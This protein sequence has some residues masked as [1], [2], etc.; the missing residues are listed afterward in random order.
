MKIFFSFLI[1][2][3]I[4]TPCF[5]QQDSSTIIKPK[6]GFKKYIIP[7]TFIVYGLSTFDQNGLPSSNEVKNFRDRNYSDF[8]TSMDD[9]LVFA[10]AAILYTFDFLKV[11]GKS[12]FLN[13]N[14]ICAKAL[15]LSLGLTY[16]LKYTT[17]ITRPDGSDN[18]SFCS[19][20]SAAAFTFAEV[21]HQ[22]F[23]EKPWIA[24]SGY[25]LATSVAAMRIANNKHW[26]SD[27]LVGAGIGMLS[28][29]LI[30][31]SHRYKWKWKANGMLVPFSTSNGQ[32]GFRYVLTF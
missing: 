20:H 6:H 8:N 14:I 27:V 2:F 4:L 3:F 10:P 25:A 17:Q 13:Q 19:G 11:K 16:L 31:A 12:D 32:N 29:K 15:T 1:S 26:L 24:I 18:L 23:K 9:Y 22:E 5:S 7:A 21:L 28:A 30:Y